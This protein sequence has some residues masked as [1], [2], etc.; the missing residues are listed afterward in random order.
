MSGPVAG[1]GSPDNNPPSKQVG[2]F[3]P[4]WLSFRRFAQ[5]IREIWSLN[6]SVAILKKDNEQFRFDIAVLQ[7]EQ[8]AQG[9]QIE[10]LIRFIDTSISERIDMKAENAAY[11]ILAG[12]QGQQKKDE[13]E[14]P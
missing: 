1:G 9:K 4:D 8:A 2:R 7:R 12:L 14:K 5:A 3:F 13:D 11:R 10:M 6:E